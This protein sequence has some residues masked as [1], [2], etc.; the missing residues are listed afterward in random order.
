LT[1]VT[2]AGVEQLF[3]QLMRPKLRTL[4]TDIYKDVSYVLDDDS[5]A[6]AE[7]QDIVR[8]RFIK[9]WESLVDGYKVCDFLTFDGRLKLAQDTFTETNYRL[10]FGL[11]LDVLLRPWEKVVVGFKFT[12][13]SLPSDSS[14][15]YSVNQ[16]QMKLGAIRFDHELRSIMAYLSSQTAFGDAREKFIRL[17]QI[18][19]L[20]NLDSVCIVF[21]FSLWTP[22]SSK[23]RKRMWM[24]FSMVQVFRGS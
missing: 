6:Q 2:Q 4:V 23:Y 3:N 24:S 17:Q 22:D 10:F 9:S 14:G 18:S 1:C 11:A 13:V 19:T 20:L 12:E 8:K 15:I 7:Y 16:F 5:Y 21:S